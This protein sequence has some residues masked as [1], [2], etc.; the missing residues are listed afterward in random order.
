MVN[1]TGKH[2][3]KR[4]R[5]GE[6]SRPF[7]V[8]DAKRLKPWRCSVRMGKDPVSGRYLAKWFS[9]TSREDVERQRDAFLA[10]RDRRAGP[11]GGMTVADALA[12]YLAE[13]RPNI[14]AST[15]DRYE[16]V[17]RRQLLPTLGAIALVA[18]RFDDIAAVRASWGAAA[19]TNN[20][21]FTVL[22]G[23]LR[24]AKRRG[25]IE[26]LPTE[27]M[28]RRRREEFQPRYLDEDEAKA[29]LEAFADDP[30]EPIVKVALV[31]GPRRGE[32]LGMQWS[33]VDLTKG[34]W[35]TNLQLR[36]I[37]A[38]DRLPGESPYRLIPPK[39]GHSRG[40]TIALPGAILD[41]LKAQAARQ[42]AW[43]VATRTWAGN[44]L[45]FTDDHGNPLVPGSVSRRFEMIATR[46]GFPGLRFHDL[47]HSAATLLLAMGVG[48]RVVQ[49]LLGHSNPAQT[50]HY[51]KVSERLGRTAAAAIDRAYRATS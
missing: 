22:Q 51:A 33:D 26:T 48:E 34:T 31:L 18:L 23:A 41:V 17:V 35:T 36:R 16:I 13:R 38:R 12:D 10:E 4:R 40:R 42:Q 37:P 32:V 30:I 7:K 5:H 19:S 50:A 15:Y 49:E 28:T 24:Y 9:G 1:P 2:R 46:A 3:P 43:R 39:A 20:Q 11:G 25:L 6:G 45:V 8:H 14:D 44:E 27:G 29:L 21:V 47:R